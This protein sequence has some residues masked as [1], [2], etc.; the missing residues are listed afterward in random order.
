MT[1]TLLATLLLSSP[2]A[3][4]DDCVSVQPTEIRNARLGG[5]RARFDLALAV[6]RTCGWSVRLRHLDF[7]VELNGARLADQRAEYGGLKLPV[8]ET[9]EIVVP[10]ELDPGMAVGASL[11][12]LTTG[13]LRL[14]LTGTA[15]VRWLFVPFDLDFDQQLVDIDLH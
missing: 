3:V 8:G 2:G 1:P 5:G 10:V 7:Q 6:Q 11:T 12:T 4:A 9:V 14:G 15:A 13:R